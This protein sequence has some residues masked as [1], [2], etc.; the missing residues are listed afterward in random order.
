MNNLKE[1]AGVVYPLLDQQ[2]YK[3]RQ[4]NY[5]NTGRFSNNMNDTLERMKKHY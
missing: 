2:S 4:I 1:L 3:P 5:E